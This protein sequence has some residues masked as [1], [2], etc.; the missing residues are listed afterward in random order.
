MNEPKPYLLT[1][2]TVFLTLIVGMMLSIAVYLSLSTHPPVIAY[3]FNS[4]ERSKTET[5]REKKDSVKLYSE[6]EK[7]ILPA[8]NIIDIDPED[9]VSLIPGSPNEAAASLQILRNEIDMLLSKRYTNAKSISDIEK[10]NEINK[11][12]AAL[13]NKNKTVEEENRQLN[14]ILKLLKQN[15]QKDNLAV[16][17]KELLEVKKANNIKIES[18]Q[19]KAVASEEWLNK[20]T[21]KA[22]QTEKLAGSVVLA[23]NN[24]AANGEILL[25]VIQPDGSVLQTSD[26]ETGIFYSNTGKQIYTKKLRFSSNDGNNKKID[27]SLQAEKYFPGKYTI[28]IYYGGALLRT[29]T[30]ILS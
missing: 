10:I 26:W 7:N 24:N 25:V 5:N 13:K 18:I 8:V 14:S 9:T 29:V 11:W 17:P 27:F 1:L 28:E 30:K 23:G 22:E 3:F 2:V 12:I 6:P 20:E 16:S 15:I 19:F 21:S 4:A